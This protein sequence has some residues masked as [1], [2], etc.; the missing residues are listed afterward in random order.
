MPRLLLALSLWLAAFTA[1][2][3]LKAGDTPPDYLGK[4]PDFREVRLADHRGRI[5][6][7]TFWA[8]WC[9]YC[10]KELPV[11]DVLQ[12]AAGERL[13]TVAVNVE[14]PAE[15][16]KAMRRQLKD[17]PMRFT[18][19]K[20]GEVAKQWDVRSYPNLYV[21]DQNGV[22]D[23]VHIGFGDGSFEEILEDVNALLARPAPP[24]LAPAPAPDAKAAGA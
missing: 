17:T 20:K 23:S 15:V 22:I 9:S 11:L 4:D 12:R 21:I 7:V 2:A 6:L 13:V 3:A 19:D 14:D 10:R 8:S 16:Y 5:V 24:P 1:Q 18:W